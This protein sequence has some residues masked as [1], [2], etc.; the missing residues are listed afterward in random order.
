MILPPVLV[1]GSSFGYTDKSE[2]V[3]T[4]NNPLGEE[5][6]APEEL[7]RKYLTNTAGDYRDYQEEE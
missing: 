6:I 2:V 5:A 3:L 1:V 7:E 4:P